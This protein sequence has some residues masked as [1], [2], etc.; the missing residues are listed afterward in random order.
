[1]PL[2][3]VTVP[4]VFHLNSCQWCVGKTRGNFSRAADWRYT[5]GKQL[6]VGCFGGDFL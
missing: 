6:G 2:S 4:L 5:L 3:R 1:M